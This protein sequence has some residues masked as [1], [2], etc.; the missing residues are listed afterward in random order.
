VS[1]TIFF[2]GGG[3]TESTQSKCREGLSQYCAKLRPHES[4]LKIVAAGGR[5][6]AFDKF[7]I[8]ALNSREGEVSVLL[9]DSESP[10]T[11]TTPIEH[12]HARDGWNFTGLLNHRVFL[13]VQA[14][15]AWFLADRAA[16]AAFYDG[17]FLANS[18]PGSPTNIEAVPKNDLEPKLIHATRPAKT[19][20]EYH[21]TKHGFELLGKIDPAKVGDA[22][23]HAKQFNEF[24]RGL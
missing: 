15:E 20:D 10:V 1:A 8:A 18:L 14:M 17:G 2:E 3:S 22:S 5:E 9:V 19:K 6:R 7:R 21:K 11:A 13:M 24:L 4:R 23:P 12:L 16:L